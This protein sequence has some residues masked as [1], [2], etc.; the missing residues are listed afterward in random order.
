MAMSRFSVE[1]PFSSLSEELPELYW[2]KEKRKEA[3]RNL[4]PYNAVRA[5]TKP[6]KVDV[7]DPSPL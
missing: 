5:F 1:K 4:L 2:S 3:I 7:R 6:R